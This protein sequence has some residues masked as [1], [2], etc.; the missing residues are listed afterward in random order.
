MAPL[1]DRGFHCATIPFYTTGRSHLTIVFRLGSLVSDLLHT[2]T[3][4][5]FKVSPPRPLHLNRS[6]NPMLKRLLIRFGE[7][8][9]YLRVAALT[10]ASPIPQAWY[11]HP[12]KFVSMDWAAMRKWLLSLSYTSSAHHV[13][14]SSTGLGSNNRTRKRLRGLTSWLIW[15]WFVCISTILRPNTDFSLE[16]RYGWRLTA[17]F[18]MPTFLQTLLDARLLA[19]VFHCF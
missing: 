9:R 17:N 7:P 6:I 11:H 15:I 16:P 1:T 18:L 10:L 19:C 4:S 14:H 12:R 3:L 2:L 13:I 5:H 8:M